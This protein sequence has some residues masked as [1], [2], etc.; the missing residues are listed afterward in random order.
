M[1][2]ESSGLA[3]IKP[4]KLS[5]EKTDYLVRQFQ[6]IL[7]ELEIMDKEK[8]ITEQ[9]YSIDE[10]IY[11]FDLEN[12]IEKYKKHQQG[13]EEDKEGAKMEGPADT[14]VPRWRQKITIPAQTDVERDEEEKQEKEQEGSSPAQTDVEHDEEEKQEKEIIKNIIKDNIKTLFYI[15]DTNMRDI[16]SKFEISSN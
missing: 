9:K 12:L 7:E 14:L 15:L 2:K 3:K 8:E 16:V 13:E 6:P 11:L 4:R 10:F 5:Y 1:G